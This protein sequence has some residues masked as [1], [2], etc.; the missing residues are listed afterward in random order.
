MDEADGAPEALVE[1]FH[2]EHERT[3]G[4]RS[5]GDPVQ[6][7]NTRLSVRISMAS[8]IGCF[9]AAP[10]FPRR[11]RQVVFGKKPLMTPVIGRASL[12]GA[13]RQGPFIVE[14][15]D[16]TCVVPPHATARLDTA[17]NIEIEVRQ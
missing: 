12:D 3:Y 16:C 9:A 4:H 14:D 7:V 11:D 8:R 6:L 13:P 17:G 2:R 10:A 5:S 15:Y 1:G